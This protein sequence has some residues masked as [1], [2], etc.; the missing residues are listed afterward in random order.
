MGIK[1]WSHEHDGLQLEIYRYGDGD[2]WIGF[3]CGCSRE[4]G[5]PSY[6]CREF[7]CFFRLCESCFQSSY[8]PQVPHHPL[9]PPHPLVLTTRY[10]TWST[11]NG[12]IC[13]GCDC[14]LVGF[15]YRCEEC[16]FNLDVNCALLMNNNRILE[17]SKPKAARRTKQH[18]I[19]PD[20]LLALFN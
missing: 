19:H 6:L 17:S 3:C 18:Y 10:A 14:F 5:G 1:H 20:H 16:D 7:G 8:P 2:S 15:V 13:D 12:Y 11:D 4:L 9:H